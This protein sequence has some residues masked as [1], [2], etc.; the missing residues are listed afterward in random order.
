[1]GRR[2]R[3]S[4]LF[5]GC[6]AHVFSRAI[7]KRYIFQSDEDFQKFKEI[8]LESKQRFSYRIHHY[9]LMHTHFHLAV[10]I[11]DTQ[12]FSAGLKWV[13]WNYA[14]YFNLKEKRF[15][16]LWRD[17]F[18]S[19]LIENENYLYA[20]GKYI[21][22]NPVAAGIVKRCEDWKHSSSR[23][24]FKG[25]GDLLI[26]PYDHSLPLIL[27]EEDKEKYFTRGYVI[28]SDLFKIHCQDEFFQG[29][30]VPL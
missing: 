15:G 8:L 11:P 28:G 26:D 2:N 22:E 9:C 24:Y 13:K 16:P 1:M 17:R 23:Y 12:K 14:R 6:Y 10:S 21:E 27:I 29:V 4:I 20:C 18:K 25:K 19:L 30:S 3:G 7:E 5:N